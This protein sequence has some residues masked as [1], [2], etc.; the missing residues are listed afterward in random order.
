VWNTNYRFDPIQGVQERAGMM[1]SAPYGSALSY[2]NRRVRERASAI[3]HHFRTVLTDIRFSEST[4]PL[5]CSGMCMLRTRTVPRRVNP[6]EDEI[7]SRNKVHSV[8]VLSKLSGYAAR[9]WVLL[10]IELGPGGRHCFQ[11]IGSIEAPRSSELP[12]GRVLFADAQN[13][14][15]QRAHR[16]P[17]L[18]VRHA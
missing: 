14:S 12:V 5:Q 7:D 8:I 10:G 17:L 15:D 6:F 13:V 3:L 16:R 4:L 18:L 2:P 1:F 11:E 9:K